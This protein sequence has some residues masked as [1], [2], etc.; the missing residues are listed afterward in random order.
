MSRHKWLLSEAQ[1]WKEE[2]LISAEQYEQLHERYPLQGRTNTLPILAGIL[3]GLG[4]LTFI[5]SNWQGI[6]VMTKL[7][8]ILVS[9][10][11][12]YGAG[13]WFQRKGQTKLGTVL[14]MVGIAIYG[15]G[16]F[17]IGQMYQL[18]ANPMLAFYLWFA[19]AIALAWYYQSRAIAWMS[20]AILTIAAFYGLDTNEYPSVWT[21]LFFYLIFAVGVVPLVL[22]YRSI[23]ISLVS[24]M[25]LLVHL[26]YDARD[27]GEGMYPPLLF[28]IFYVISLLLP[29]RLAPLP[30]V[31]QGVSYLASIVFAVIL[32][33]ANDEFWVSGTVD[34]AI[35]GLILLFIAYAAVRLR[36][37][38][39]LEK[40]SD[41][42]LY[43]AFVLVYFLPPQLTWLSGS[44]LI[45]LA[46]A[47]FAIGMIMG[48]ERLRDV[49]RINLGA[50]AF[51][52]TCFVGYTHYAW[53]FMDKSLFFFCGG[54]LLLVLS[55]FVERKRRQ[56]VSE[57]RGNRP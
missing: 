3:I 27:V 32:I 48:G 21:T 50:I 47:V 12:A 18:S 45:I 11:L 40:A 28:L 56:W 57:A 33:F 38:Q 46:L 49:T 34:T 8:M 14:T 1:K 4:A 41:L 26:L 22:K 54:L 30:L 6:G 44:V 36:Q 23:A 43:L 5:A 10:V 16:F 51:G 25:L 52:I 37:L 7:F 55:F 19:G 24:S 15:A 2:Q 9:L 39:T 17:L 53:A 13:D 29:A 35:A 20:L 42:I 31:L